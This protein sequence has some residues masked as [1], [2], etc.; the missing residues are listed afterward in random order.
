MRVPIA[1]EIERMLGCNQTETIFL[2]LK[3]N[4]CSQLKIEEWSEDM[5]TDIPT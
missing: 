3:N 2:I 5:E 1:D 4:K